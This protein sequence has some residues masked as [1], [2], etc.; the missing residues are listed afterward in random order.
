MSITSKRTSTQPMKRALE[1]GVSSTIESATP[2]E[3]SPAERSGTPS[4]LCPKNL[5][6]YDKL[7]LW[8]GMPRRNDTAGKSFDW[9]FLNE[10][11]AVS[12]ALMS[13]VTVMKETGNNNNVDVFLPDYIPSVIFG[14]DPAYYTLD[15]NFANDKHAIETGQYR[16]KIRLTE[17]HAPQGA[18]NLNLFPMDEEGPLQICVY[19]PLEKNPQDNDEPVV[20]WRA[21]SWAFLHPDVQ[22]R[23]KTREWWK[24]E[25]KNQDKSQFTTMAVLEMLTGYR[26]EYIY[27][28]GSD[29]EK[30]LGVDDTLQD[31]SRFMDWI[32]GDEIDDNEKKLR[33]LPT[34]NWNPT[35]MKS[36]DT[37]IRAVKPFP[38]GA[39]I[40][41]Q[42]LVALLDTRASGYA[43]NVINPNDPEA[44]DR[45]RSYDELF[46]YV[47]QD[48]E[49]QR[50]SMSWIARLK[51]EKSNKSP[52]AGAEAR[53]ARQ[54]QGIREMEYFEPRDFA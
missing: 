25:L 17:G 12:N 8:D 13:L 23:L 29:A 44:V 18:V 32:L 52:L 36:R 27:K 33:N 19:F 34:A 22:D 30:F 38:K 20:W 41:P 7:I 49:T 37:G 14:A 42:G 48:E 51:L 35:I 1:D 6:R 9:P 40:T 50:L 2:T 28:K 21:L 5:K 54:K 4:K 24:G 10:I 26:A 46:D 43:T 47:A 39:N 15:E 3:T 53:V 31:K 45:H 16:P 11:G